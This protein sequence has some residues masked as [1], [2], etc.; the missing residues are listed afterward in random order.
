MA[1]V[2]WVATSTLVFS[3]VWCP[4]RLRCV[5]LRWF[6]AEIGNGVLIKHKVNVQWPWK[7]SIGDNSWVGVGADLYN[8]ADIRIGSDVCISQHA[9]LCTGSHDRHSPT[10]EFDN[11]PIVVEDGAWLCARSMVLRGV[12]IGS[13]SVIGAMCL[14]T[15]DV[16]AD[17]VVRVPAPAISSD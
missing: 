9:Y 13:N 4:S 5:L 11:G 3:Q 10:F 12:T 16:P 2:L 7:L 8:L 15:S 14:V 6:G 1:Q 17:S